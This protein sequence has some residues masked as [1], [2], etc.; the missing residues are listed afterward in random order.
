MTLEFVAVLVYVA[1][2]LVIGFVISRRIKSEDD[3]LLAGR[4]LGPV[5]I[6]ASTFA[7]WFGAETCI[8]AAGGAY[9]DGF[10]IT[11][12]P[13]GYG[14]AVV[15]TGVI[16]AA[17]LWRRQVTTLADVFRVRFSPSVERATALI[18]IPSSV[19]W[20]AAQI[21][22]FGHVVSAA[23]AWPMELSIAVAA[24]V[25]IA[26]TAGGGMLADVVTDLV[27]GAVLIVGLV[28]LTVVALSLAPELAPQ[29]AAPAPS[30]P[31][32]E[33]LWARIDAWAIP[34][35]GSLV[36]QELIA[37]ALSAR[38]A[39]V[40]RGATV[41]GG[42]LYLAVG[43]LPLVLGG[44]A[45]KAGVVV[46]DPEQALP[47]LASLYL[48]TVGYAIFVGAI[49][50]A[51]LS[52]VDSALLVAGTFLAHNVLPALKPRLNDAQKLK[53]ARACVTVFGLLAWA[54]AYTGDSV[55]DLVEEA[56]AFGSA[57]VVVVALFGVFTRLGHTP[58][59]LGAL[60]A[61]AATWSLGRHAFHWDA[62]Y[63]TALGAA[64][65]T[66]LALAAW[67][68]KEPATTARA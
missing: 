3:Y 53:A 27:Q 51:I 35:C 33:P 17:T 32:A 7:T 24:V 55:S 25:V 16:F 15:L 34:L 64:L 14:I 5:M 57:G 18:L 6:A 40:A 60:A 44:L 22:A 9:E 59:A 42:L 61:G 47:K 11:P 67:K 58:S 8:S 56:G 28:V 31:E 36:A 65:G 23:S 66:Y 2:Q 39:K 48:P 10:S 19:I 62:S 45:M 20:A 37:R 1:L 52:T 38:S 4:K 41:A 30:P 68:G 43:C 50:S 12:E 13:F 49:V 54:L 63:L 29:A 46:S 26:Y 21:R